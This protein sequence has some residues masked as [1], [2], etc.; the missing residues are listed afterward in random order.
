MAFW[1]NM[2]EIEGRIALATVALGST[3]IASQII[4]LREFLSAFYGNELVIGIVLANWMVITGIGSYFGKY[5]KGFRSHRTLL[6]TLFA[7]FALLP[8]LTVLVIRLAR[9]IVFTTGSTVGLTELLCASFVVLLPFCLLSG[10]LFTAIA[11]LASENSSGNMIRQ[12][13]ALESAGSAIGGLVF[14]L[15]LIFVFTTFQSLIFIMVVNAL[16]ALFLSALSMRT[17]II[18]ALATI[19]VVLA[20]LRIDLDG[21]TRKRLFAGQ[22]LLFHGDTPYGNLAVTRQGDQT[23]FFENGVPLFSTNDIVANEEAVH[24][25]MSQHH[26]P[27]S[28]L[29]ISGGSSGLIREILK[30]DVQQVDYVELNPWLITIVRQFD[31]L[32]ND[33]K[34]RVINEDGRRYVKKSSRKYDIVL[35]NV[36]DPTTAQLN[37]FYTQGFFAELKNVLNTNAVVSMS[38]LSSADY[39]SNESR[40]LRSVLYN[41]LETQFTKILIIPGSRDYFIAS[42]GHLDYQITKLVRERG[43]AT[44]YVNGNYLNDDLQKERG[45][46]IVKGL[47]RQSSLNEDFTPVAYLRQLSYWL[48]QF[49]EDS[50]VL[51]AGSIAL[52]VFFAMRMDTIAL[53]I[54]AGGFAASSIEIVV[55]ISFQILYGYVYYL[56][57]IIITV[58]MAGLAV[59]A[60]VQREKVGR[61]DYRTFLLMQ[62]S[63]AGCAIL[64]PFLL[65]ILQKLSDS[66]SLVITVLLLFTLATAFW[67]GAEFGVATRLQRGSVPTIASTLYSVDLLGSAIGALIVSSYLIPLIGVAKVC[68]VVAA[69]NLMSAGV[70][71]LKRKQIAVNY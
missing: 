30:Y 1:K 8:L 54:F 17:T 42:D 35:I 63:I 69:L 11:R 47:D 2:T 24:Y 16:V 7:S 31:S 59:G 62:V 33:P 4:L 6:P 52:F 67:I 45:T 68:T 46:A 60:L 70:S 57:G 20:L 38:L 41:T 65:M 43:I 12:V 13:Y 27:K 19:I 66:S 58:F 37:R 15:I 64:F 61:S 56:A 18:A 50:W 49:R 40:Q 51:A 21:F 5:G 10:F 34:V 26:N 48:S 53:G 28:V 71:L 32:P 39:L 36:P 44:V 25:A 9:N 3:S 29:L 55:L 22:D 23:N 14:S